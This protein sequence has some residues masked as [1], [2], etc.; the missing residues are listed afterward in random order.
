MITIIGK[1]DSKEFIILQ[2]KLE[3]LTVSYRMQYTTDRA[4]IQDGQIK[5]QGEDKIDNYFKELEQD[6]ELWY[7]CV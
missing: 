6:L 3:K 7:Y 5:I 1:K 4:Y 2:E